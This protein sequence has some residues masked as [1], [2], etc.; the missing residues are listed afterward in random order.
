MKNN[1]DTSKG[2]DMSEQQIKQM[3]DGF[4]SWEL[5]DDFS[6]DGGVSYKQ[7]FSGGQPLKPVGTNL[8]TATQAEQMIRY[9][10]GSSDD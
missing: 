10:L 1:N 5:P 7:V 9:I 4:L 6:P 2:E 8:L 3:V